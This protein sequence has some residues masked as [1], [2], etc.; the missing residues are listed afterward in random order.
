[1]DKL[2]N[3]VSAIQS[4][5][6]EYDPIIHTTEDDHWDFAVTCRHYYSDGKATSFNFTPVVELLNDFSEY[7]L[8]S[9]TRSEGPLH[10]EDDDGIN[11]H[12]V[13]ILVRV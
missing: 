4:E 5:N 11:K 7:G 2:L 8:E 12:T 9:F 1:M 6:W 10:V 3:L 13:E